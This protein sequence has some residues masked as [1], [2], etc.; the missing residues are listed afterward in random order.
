MFKTILI[1]ALITLGFLGTCGVH[2]QDLG[3]LSLSE[4]K[5][6]KMSCDAELAKL[7]LSAYDLI[8]KMGRHHFHHHKS[9]LVDAYLECL[10]SG[11]FPNMDELER[12]VSL[13]M[14]MGSEIAL[15]KKHYKDNCSEPQNECSASLDKG[16]EDGTIKAANYVADKRKCLDVYKRC[17]S[18]FNTSACTSKLQ[19]Q[20]KG[21]ASAEILKTCE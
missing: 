2:A 17:L 14:K 1:T 21:A 4:F 12:T 6:R 20:M 10:E 19:S 16:L 8:G 11:K 18:E 15:I 9:K 13:P 3:K 7:K 5:S